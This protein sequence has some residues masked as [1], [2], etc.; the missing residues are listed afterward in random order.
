MNSN[1]QFAGRIAIFEIGAATLVA[2]VALSIPKPRPVK[3]FEQ[4]ALN[5]PA[6]HA[7]MQQQ[8]QQVRWTDYM[9]LVLRSGAVI[10]VTGALMVGLRTRRP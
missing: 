8:Q 1:I 6:M 7:A 2:V 10:L 9:P 4:I 5:D 3:G